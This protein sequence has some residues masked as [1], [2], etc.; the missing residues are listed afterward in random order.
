MVGTEQ[1]SGGRSDV[2]SASDFVTM[3]SGKGGTGGGDWGASIGGGGGAKGGD[4]IDI[5]TLRTCRKMAEACA[6]QMAENKFHNMR[7]QVMSYH[8]HGEDGMTYLLVGYS[9]IGFQIQSNITIQ[10]KRDR[11]PD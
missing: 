8:R 7:W 3:P 2:L 11:V 4:S 10:A 1:E 6:G 5:G 9:Q